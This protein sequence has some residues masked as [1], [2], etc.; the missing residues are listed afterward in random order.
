MAR[1]QVK[2]VSR[3]FH[4]YHLIPVVMAAAALPS[5]IIGKMTKQGGLRVR[6]V[7][8]KFSPRLSQIREENFHRGQINP[9]APTSRARDSVFWGQASDW[10]RRVLSLS[11]MWR[12]EVHETKPMTRRAEMRTL[13]RRF[14]K[15]EEL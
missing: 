13:S 8:Y 2:N 5:H 11:E 6:V 14:L 15:I 1:A 7:V 4:P 3:H 10:R 9:V 12:E